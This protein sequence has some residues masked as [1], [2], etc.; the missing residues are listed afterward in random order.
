MNPTGRAGERRRREI[1]C[2]RKG[3][4]RFRIRVPDFEYDTG[5]SRTPV[6]TLPDS[7]RADSGDEAGTKEGGP[8]MVRDG[9]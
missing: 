5:L 8:V 7:S 9:R 4:A 6:P 2:R 3:A 1:S